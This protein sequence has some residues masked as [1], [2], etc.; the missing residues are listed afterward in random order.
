MN[1][2]K[3]LQ[4]IFIVVSL[5]SSNDLSAQKKL[6]FE[7]IGNMK[8]DNGNFSITEVGSDI[9]AIGGSTAMQ[10]V[11]SNMQVYDN[12][13]K[14]WLNI[15]LNGLDR[16][17]YGSAIYLEKYNSIL[18]AGG[19]TPFGSSVKIV[20]K[21]RLV[22]TDKFEVKEIGP[23]PA[24]TKN[25]GMAYFN[26]K[27]YMFGGGLS[28][29]RSKTGTEFW[30]FSNRLYSFEISTGQIE[31]LPDLP[32]AMETEG[33][34]YNGNL[35]L[36]GGFD[37]RPRSTVYKYNLELKEWTSLNGLERPLSNYSLVQ[38]E[39][40]FLLIGDR[41]KDNQLILFNA[42]TE[43]A[44]YFKTNLQGRRLGASILDDELFIYGGSNTMLGFRKSSVYK[45]DVDKILN[46]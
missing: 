17:S 20:D 1:A 41:S 18:L 14:K 15:P 6:K 32:N 25:L 27:V 2:F 28:Y 4:I 5:C 23:A 33:G 21:L 8:V 35:Y 10:W 24:P 36:F 39:N 40:Y 42:D 43:E 29:Y 34:I 31:R 26:D 45:I 37:S 13:I 12:R 3:S 46:N 7:K 30:T 19:I 16:F 38:Y 44:T 11:S 9:Y 22:N